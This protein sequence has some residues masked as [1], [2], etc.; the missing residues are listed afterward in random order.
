MINEKSAR[1]FIFGRAFAKAFPM[2]SHPLIKIPKYNYISTHISSLSTWLMTRCLP[3]THSFTISITSVIN[4]REKK[5]IITVRRTYCAIVLV[6]W[7]IWR[8]SDAIERTYTPKRIDFVTS[9]KFIYHIYGALFGS[10]YPVSQIFLI[11]H[12]DGYFVWSLAAGV[13]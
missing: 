9:K 8:F 2:P 4:N 6:P 1:N 12:Q 5:Q 11:I 10:I 13:N 7:L 3:L